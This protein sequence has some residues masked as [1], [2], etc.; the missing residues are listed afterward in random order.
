[1][2]LHSA[3]FYLFFFIKAEYFI[4]EFRFRNVDDID[5]F[6]KWRQLNMGHQE[7]TLIFSEVILSDIYYEMSNRSG[8][9]FGFT[10]LKIS[11]IC[12]TFQLFLNISPLT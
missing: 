1:M 8:A 10:G 9:N 11:S 12:I 4:D 3:R 5:D 7:V 6:T 2:R